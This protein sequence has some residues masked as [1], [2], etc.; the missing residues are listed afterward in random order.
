MLLFLPH[1]LQG[2]TCFLISAELSSQLLIIQDVV[3]TNL[4]GQMQLLVIGEV[5][6]KGGSSRPGL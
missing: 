2:N 5:V 3:K 4:L 6:E 1:N